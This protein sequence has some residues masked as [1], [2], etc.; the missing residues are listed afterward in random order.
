MYTADNFKCVILLISYCSANTK[1]T[2]RCYYFYHILVEL[3]CEIESN[4]YL[5]LCLNTLVSTS[6]VLESIIFRKI[7]HIMNSIYYG[8]FKLRYLYYTRFTHTF[9]DGVCS[10]IIIAFLQCLLLTH[11][12]MLSYISRNSLL[13]RTC[14]RNNT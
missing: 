7:Y 3:K 1:Y 8:L 11:L 14:C 12:I 9:S 6:F 2:T 5:I 13:S 10:N 4:A